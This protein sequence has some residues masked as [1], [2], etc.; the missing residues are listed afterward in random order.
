MTGPAGR[1]IDRIQQL[2]CENV[3]SWQALLR[4]WEMSDL[5]PQ[6]EAKWTL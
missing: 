6:S 3:S 2:S 4:P 5:T 1:R